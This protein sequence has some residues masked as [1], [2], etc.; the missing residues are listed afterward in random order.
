MRRPVPLLLLLI[1][2]ALGFGP[3]GQVAATTVRP[4]AFTELVRES[5]YVV[6]ARARKV[7]SAIHERNGRKWIESKITLEVLEVI[8]GAPPSPLVLTMLGGRVGDE[9]MVVAGAPIFAVGDEDI[10]FVQGNGVNF[11]PL[12]AMMHG[13]YPVKHDAATGRDYVTRN[14]GVPLVDVAEV[15]LP[16]GEAGAPGAVLQRR[17]RRSADAL[18][19][20]D[21]ARRIRETRGGGGQAR[22][23]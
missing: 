23:K 9:I 20:A 18:T 12:Y 7:E 2:L 22:E 1:T 14:D 3:G 21:F 6:R 10:L 19:P 13:R 5:D 15:A 11:H 4:P 8:A 16:L 17:L